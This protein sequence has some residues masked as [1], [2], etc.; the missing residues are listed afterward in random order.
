MQLSLFV[1]HLF[2]FWVELVNS[3]DSRE[4]FGHT[5]VVSF[6]FSD[7]TYDCVVFLLPMLQVGNEEMPSPCGLYV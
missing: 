5:V 3:V 2:E 4:A 6:W 7:C 1:L